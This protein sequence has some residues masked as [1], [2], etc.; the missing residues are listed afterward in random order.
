MRLPEGATHGTDD[1]ARV[2]LALGARRF[3][4]G[5]LLRGTTA[6]LRA[7]AAGFVDAED[8][9]GRAGDD[10]AAAQLRHVVGRLAARGWLERAVVL[11][12]VRLATLRPVGTP[13]AGPA[14]ALGAGRPVALSRFAAAHRSGASLVLTSPRSSWS[15]G[16]DDPRVGSLVARLAAPA[17]PD[18]P[19]GLPPGAAA[20]VLALLDDAGLLV[21][22]P[23]GAGSGAE[24]GDQAL[25]QWS[26]TDLAFHAATRYGRQD[27]GYGGTFPLAGRFLPLPEHAEPAGPFVALARPGPAAGEPSFDAVLDAR[28]S[29][30]EHDNRSPITVAQLGDFLYRAAGVRP[31]TGT[32]PYPSGGGLYELELYPAVGRC[33]GLEAG[34]Y[35]YDAVEHRLAA[36]ADGPAVRRLLDDARRRCLMARTPQVLVVVAARFGRVMYKYEAIAYATILKN[37]GALYQTMYCVAT[38]MGLAPCALGGGSADAFCEAAGTDY[39]VESSVG[40]FLVGSR[41]QGCGR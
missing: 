41:P 39:L 19:L 12:G 25:A 17:A 6:A 9:A 33:D 3:A 11:D 5:P 36:V 35:R 18:D 24:D 22:E 28:C 32:R 37:V 23:A 10:E 16:V 4:I 7:L 26:R 2:V 38:A 27:G 34:L 13:V 1:Q 21:A 30:R 14:A 29:I 20:A 15:V 31:A 40:E 8:L